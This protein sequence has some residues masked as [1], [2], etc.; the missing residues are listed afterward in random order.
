LLAAGGLDVLPPARRRR[1]PRRREIVMA[2]SQPAETLRT[3]S[4][5][6]SPSPSDAGAPVGERLLESARA[7]GPLIREHAEQAEREGRLAK[8]VVEALS[9]AGF[10]SMFTPRSLGGLELD[11]VTVARVVE[12]ISGFDSAAGWMLQGNTNGWWSS[13]FPEDGVAEIYAGGPDPRMAATF[14]PPHRA[15]PVPGGYRFTGRGTLASGIHE[16]DWVL[17][18]AFVMDGDRPKM[19]DV[20]PIVIA[21]T[22]RTSEVEIVDTWRSLGMRGTD[23]N[24][25]SAT[26]V[27]VPVARTFAFAPNPALGKHYQGPL[28]RIPALASTI[29]IVPPVALALARGAIDE[30]RDLAGKKTPLGSMKTLRDRNAV[31]SALAEAEATLRSARL[32]LHDALGEA[33]RRASAGQE[34]TLEQ[35]AE[36]LLAGAHAVRSASRVVDLMHRQA[37]SSGI[38]QRS[39]LERLFRDAQTVRQHGVVCESRF[40]AVGQVMLGVAPEFVLVGL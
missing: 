28:Y 36:V 6:H 16:A 13:R 21:L 37:G 3:Q 33:W 2:T 10:Q 9:R 19:T 26:D 34:S 25:V 30:V 15:V 22:M 27:F 24:D 17:L 23:S 7:L 1:I 29:A 5:L 11:P 32:L 4:P 39:R 20:G 14:H 8:P 40:E 18:S 38:Y 35:K 31:Q 12:E